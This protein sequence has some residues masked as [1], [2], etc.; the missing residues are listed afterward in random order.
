MGYCA[1]GENERI[2]AIV[3][4]NKIAIKEFKVDKDI[5]VK[6]SKQDLSLLLR[7]L[8]NCCLLNNGQL[9]IDSSDFPN[10]LGSM[11]VIIGEESLTF[12]FDI[13]PASMGGFLINTGCVIVLFIS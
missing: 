5:S 2:I 13:I 1:V 11:R 10:C 9:S 3:G 4:G 12:H 8:K 6:N 7:A